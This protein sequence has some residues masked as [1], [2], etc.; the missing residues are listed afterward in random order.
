[1][2]MR[3]RRRGKNYVESLANILNLVSKQQQQL[4]P[5]MRKRIMDSI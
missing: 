5:Y 3:E 2:K 1:M 4:N